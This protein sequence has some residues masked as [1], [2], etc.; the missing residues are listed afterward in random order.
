MVGGHV[1]ALETLPLTD[2]A[3]D[4]RR[5]EACPIVRGQALSFQRPKDSTPGTN[6]RS[7]TDYL[8][9]SPRLTF[10][11]ISPPTHIISPTRKT[12]APKMSESNSNSQ[13]SSGVSRK[14]ASP[15][16]IM[17]KASTSYLPNFLT[18]L[19][20]LPSPSS[21]TAEVGPGRHIPDHDSQ[22]AVR[23]LPATLQTNANC[24]A[25]ALVSPAS[26]VRLG[27]LLDHLGELFLGE[28]LD[29][30]CPGVTLCG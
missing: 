1:T 16:P 26:S 9:C 13:S 25:P 14:R 3:P 4:G 27:Q 10:L 19:F 5:I 20:I 15:T 21:R 29:R 2:T 30:G 6:R 24:G 22:W 28:C 12:R 17:T 18:S 7:P 11:A 23:Q 8:A